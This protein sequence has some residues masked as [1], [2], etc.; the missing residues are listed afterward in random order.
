MGRAHENMMDELGLDESK[1]K[2]DSGAPHGYHFRVSRKDEKAIRDADVN[3]LA[4]KKDGVCFRDKTLEKLAVRYKDLASKYVAYIC[5]YVYVH[6][7]KYVGFTLTRTMYL[8]TYLYMSIQVT[9]SAS[10]IKRWKTRCTLYGSRQQV[11][12]MY[13][14]IQING[15]VELGYPMQMCVCIHMYIYSSTW[16][17]VCFRDNTL[18]KL[19]VRY[20]D[21]ASKY[22]AYLYVYAYLYIRIY[23]IYVRRCERPMWTFWPRRKTASAFVIKR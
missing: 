23:V 12:C 4:T 1:V 8:Y 20:K 13:M 22:V 2:L 14:C 19:A 15:Y 6:I 3:I 11:R 17:G 21:L 9:I 5:I 18:E 10:V 7:C 16:V